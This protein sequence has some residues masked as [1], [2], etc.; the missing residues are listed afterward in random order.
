MGLA[1]LALEIA[2]FGATQTWRARAVY[3]KPS[4]VHLLG[5]RMIIGYARVSTLDQNLEL[6]KDALEKAGCEQVFEDHV[7]GSTTER[8]GWAQAQ[9]VLRKGDT[10]VVWRLDRLGRSLKHLIDTVNELHARGIG[11]KSLNENIDTTTPGG[12]LVFHIFGALA[13]FERELIRERTQ[14]GLAAARARGRKGGR[15]RKL[16]MRQVET[17][18]TLLGDGK[19]SATEVAKTLGVSRATLYR[20]LV[21]EKR[22]EEAK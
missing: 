3:R 16:A 17:A 7:S 15:P 18:K 9:A 4:D 8:P 19:L 22:N 2:P 13:E 11:F 10:L 14:A 12:R 6:Q 1:P 20:Y 5:H 21:E